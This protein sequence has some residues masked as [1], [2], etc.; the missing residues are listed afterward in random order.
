MSVICITGHIPAAKG[1]NPAQFAIYVAG[2]PSLGG[3][4]LNRNLGGTGSM[5][6]SQPIKV[7]PTSQPLR[8]GRLG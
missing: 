7:I 1:S 2:A 6:N 4:A 3:K 5:R 8:I